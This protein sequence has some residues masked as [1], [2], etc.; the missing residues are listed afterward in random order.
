MHFGIDYGSKMAGTTVI[1]YEEDDHL[2]QISS[3]KKQDADA[4]I[5]DAA[6]QLQPTAIFIDAP[7][8]LP[9]AYFG[10]GD[11]YF[12]RKADRVLKAMS[13]MFLGGLTARAMKLTAELRSSKIEVFET[14]PGALIRSNLALSE[15]YSKKGK[16][17][18]PEMMQSLQSYLGKYHVPV[19]PENIHQFDSLLTWYSG[20]RHLTGTSVIIGDKEEG[21]I[22]Y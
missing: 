4:M 18:I 9:N 13:P 15:V 5:I 6:K 12:Y 19:S 21:V 14:Y 1:T 8:S 2:L 17:H 3:S 22:V 11:D 16:D 20:Y 10:K 7:L